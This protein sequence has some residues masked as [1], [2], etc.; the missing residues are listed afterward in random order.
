[1]RSTSVP[2]CTMVVALFLLGTSLTKAQSA[3]PAPTL[4]SILL[5]QLRETHNQ[6]Q[7]FV[8]VKV[9]IEGL[10]AEQAAWK[11]G[12]DN[13]SIAQL[14]NHLIFWNKQQ[15]AKFNGEKP[16][17]FSGDNNE[18]FAG[19]DKAAW[20]ASVKQIDDVL[21]AW[22]K[23]IEGA[24]DAKLAKWYSTIGRISTHNAYHT[25]QIIY[26]RKMKGNWDP[27]KGVK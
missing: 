13:H 15:L 8:P 7:W 23:A 21:T 25:G 10:T 16:V 27:A 2:L 26:I 5:E 11:D 3:S 14:V 1:M 19:L 12:T 4:K 24:D 9:A 17:A 18:T 20:D 22:E 6:E